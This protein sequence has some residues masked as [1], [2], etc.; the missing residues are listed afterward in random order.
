[1]CVSVR[2]RDRQSERERERERERAAGAGCLCVFVIDGRDRFGMQL[3]ATASL[4]GYRGTPLI[5]NCALLGPYSWNVPRI[6]WRP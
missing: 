1:M 6:L 4:C 5:R 2:E 3:I